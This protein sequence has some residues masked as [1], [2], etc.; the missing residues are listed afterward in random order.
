MFFAFINISNQA[1]RCC[2]IHVYLTAVLCCTYTISCKTSVLSCNS[3]YK[4]K[5]SINVYRFCVYLNVQPTQGNRRSS[6]WSAWPFHCP[7]NSGQ[8]QCVHSSIEIATKAELFNVEYSLVQ[9]TSTNFFI[10]V[11]SNPYQDRSNVMSMDTLPM[12]SS[13]F[14]HH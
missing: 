8:W 2:T 4:Q 9:N 13:A 5:P 11:N 12:S 6:Q 1:W 14:S 3:R 10:S 7:L